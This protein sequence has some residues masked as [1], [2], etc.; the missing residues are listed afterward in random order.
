MLLSP[1]KKAGSAHYPDD[2]VTPRFVT[3]G[4]GR[5]RL[6]GGLPRGGWVSTSPD[7]CR[8]MSA[9]TLNNS[10]IPNGL[11]NSLLVPDATGYSLAGLSVSP[12]DPAWIGKSGWSLVTYAATGVHV[13]SERRIASHQLAPSKPP[14]KYLGSVLLV[15]LGFF[16]E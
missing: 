16:G 8:I 14:L 1:R 10:L 12:N 3:T 6:E 15:L 13:P 4:Y 5:Y 11:V 2:V 7:I 9:F